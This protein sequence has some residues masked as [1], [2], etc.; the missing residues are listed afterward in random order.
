M[1]SLGIDEIVV[2]ESEQLAEFA[3]VFH[4]PPEPFAVCL[5]PRSPDDRYI[6][7]LQLA[8]LGGRVIEPL[9]QYLIPRRSAGQCVGN[10]TVAAA[11]FGAVVAVVPARVS[12]VIT[13]LGNTAPL[14]PVNRPG[15]CRSALP[16]GLLVK[17][18]LSAQGRELARHAQNVVVVDIG[19]VVPTLF[20]LSGQNTITVNAVQVTEEFTCFGRRIRIDWIVSTIHADRTAAAA[21]SAAGSAARTAAG[22][23][24]AG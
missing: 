13:Y 17:E 20:L 23:A 21:R 12:H 14:P 15:G 3:A 7:C 10:A 18:I 5:V 22:T 4:S 24:A 19:I 16:V 2:G 9:H 8:K 11:L 6:G 1:E